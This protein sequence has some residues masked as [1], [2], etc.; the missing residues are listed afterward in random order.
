[1]GAG[2]AD[3]IAIAASGIATPAS[4]VAFCAVDENPTTIVIGA[5]LQV[6]SRLAE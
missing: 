2:A 3:A 6:A 5:D 1:M 4:D